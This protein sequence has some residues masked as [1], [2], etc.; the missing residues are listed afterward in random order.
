MKKFLLLWV[1]PLVTAILVILK[2]KP[3]ED[4]LKGV[5]S[6]APL[7][8]GAAL[9]ILTLINHYLNVFSPFKKYEKWAR[10]K[11]FILNKEAEK[12][13]KYYK[14][15]GVDI[16]IN[17]MVPSRKWFYR[18]EPKKSDKSKRIFSITGIVFKDIWSYPN[19][20]N[21][22]LCLTLNQGICGRTYRQGSDI[23]TIEFVNHTAHSFNL[24]SKQEE[25]TKNI[26]FIA[27]RPITILE[28]GSEQQEKRI[29]GVLNLESSTKGA[30]K[31]LLEKNLKDELMNQLVLFSQICS[32]L[33]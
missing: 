9:V 30:E 6:N 20:V 28:D 8:I 19:Q 1:A 31:V 29:L 32:K 11:W 26:V 7:I 2:V 12:L 24:N 18:I 5:D 17:I 16:N 27:S 33:L 25:L 13:V 10:N 22:L 15:M 14:Q 3:V 23:L 4:Y 21:K